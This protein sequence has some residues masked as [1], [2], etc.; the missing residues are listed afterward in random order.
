MRHP[1]SEKVQLRPALGAVGMCSFQLLKQAQQ[2][3]AVA[4]SVSFQSHRGGWMSQATG[5][6]VSSPH[7]HTDLCDDASQAEQF[8][9]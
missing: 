4:I 1:E 9:R 8:P 3:A 6:S 5:H 2:M 7:Q